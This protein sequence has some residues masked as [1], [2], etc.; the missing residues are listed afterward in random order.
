MNRCHRD[1]FDLRAA[2]ALALG[3]TAGAPDDPP[4]PP[5]AGAGSFDDGEPGDTTAGTVVG[6]AE[7]EGEDDQE[8]IKNPR[9]KELSDEA[10]KY[11]RQRREAV[12]RAEAAE[13]RIKELEAEGGLKQQV[14]TL[15]DDNRSLRLRLV[16][17]RAASIVGCKDMDAAWK[18]AAEGLA[19]VDVKDDTVDENK[20]GEIVTHLTERHPY[21]FAWD[22]E[23]DT[24]TA[25]KKDAFPQEASGRPM[26]GKRH[27][28][29]STTDTAVLAKRFPALHRR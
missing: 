3:T 2:F 17:E 29:D 28:S 27:T 5:A 1:P 15:T 22:D 6:H 10:A 11:R 18:L 13:K 23:Q 26:N 9:M 14:A 4:S 25:D 7:E 20:V 8:A 19:A 21:F 12:E 16:F 24:G